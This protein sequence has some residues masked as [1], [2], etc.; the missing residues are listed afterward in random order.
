MRGLAEYWVCLPR[1]SQ[2]SGGCAA[3]RIR[4][5]GNAS[6]IPVKAFPDRAAIPGIPFSYKAVRERALVF[7]KAAP[8]AFA[9]RQDC[10]TTKNKKSLQTNMLESSFYCLSITGKAAGDFLYFTSRKPQGHTAER[11]LFLR[12]YILRPDCAGT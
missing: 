11:S 2:M 9:D 8:K 12:S 10:R 5:P 3:F 7:C 6:K 4:V 1:S